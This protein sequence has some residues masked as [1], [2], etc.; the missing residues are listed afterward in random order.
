MPNSNK[1]DPNKESLSYLIMYTYNQESNNQQNL[2]QGSYL[3]TNNFEEIIPL[4]HKIRNIDI[5]IRVLP[6]FP[7]QIKSIKQTIELV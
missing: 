6:F 5:T 7:S 4:V 2:D 3:I 1:P